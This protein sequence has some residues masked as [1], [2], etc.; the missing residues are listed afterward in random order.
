MENNPLFCYSIFNERNEGGV[1]V[2]LKKNKK[3]KKNEVLDQ[4]TQIQE[5]ENVEITLEE[6]EQRFASEGSMDDI[7]IEEISELNKSSVDNFE[8]K[9]ENNKRREHLTAKDD[10][11]LRKKEEK[12]ARAKRKLWN[13]LFAVF[14]LVF[15]VLGIKTAFPT[16]TEQMFKDASKNVSAVIFGT[17]NTDVQKRIETDINNASQGYL[18]VSLVKNLE[19]NLS[20]DSLQELTN[21]D[22]VFITGVPI[23]LNSSDK[24][25]FKKNLRVGNYLVGRDLPDGLFLAENAEIKI[26]NTTKDF[27]KQRNGESVSIKREFIYLKKG[28]LVTIKKLGTL[29]P[30]S[31]VEKKIIPLN[32]IETGKEYMVGVDLEAGD[33]KLT[34]KVKGK[35]NHTNALNVF[36]TKTILE[37]QTITLKK[38]EIVSFEGIKKIEKEN[39]KEK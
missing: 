34:P 29:T 16:Q 23:T 26:Y 20:L 19:D 1:F 22:S 6:L 17:I 7:T 25:N 24:A 37:P 32:S 12:K 35:L 8:F 4:N 28:Q 14:V 31:F 39:K 10:I 21:S 36:R 11:S 9:S 33:Y 2:L 13:G 30:T 18:N 15:L 27:I 5:D 3:D 38:G